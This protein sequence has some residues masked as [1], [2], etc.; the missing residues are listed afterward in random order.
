MTDI[1]LRERSQMIRQPLRYEYRDPAP[2][3]PQGTLVAEPLPEAEKPQPFSLV[4]LLMPLLMLTMVG[5]MVGFMVMSG[6]QLNPMMLMFPIMMI[7]G[8]FSMFSGG[9]TEDY[10]ETRRTYLRHLKALQQQAQKAQVAQ[11]QH[12]LHQHPH[13]EHLWSQLGS[14]RM[15]ER[16]HQ[17]PDAYCVRIGLGTQALCTPFDLG[18]PA[19]PEDVDPVC[20]YGLKQLVTNF[21]TIADM[22]IVIHLRSF[23]ALDFSGP[24][25]HG[26]VFSLL[27]E[28][29][30]FHGPETIGIHCLSKRFSASI[31]W[32]PHSHPT[33]C[34]HAQ[35]VIV[36]V[37][38]E[39]TDTAITHACALYTTTV[40]IGVEARAGIIHQH[41]AT[42]G[43]AF[44]VNNQH[45][46][47]AVTEIGA[48]HIGTSD[49]ISEQ[50]FALFTRKMTKYSR[51]RHIQHNHT[52]EL[53]QLLGVDDF[54]A[55][56][57]EY[58]WHPRGRQ[59]LAV[60]LGIGEDH[61]PVVLDIKEASQGGMGPHGLC[62]GATGSGKSELLRT[63]VVGL[64]AT[65]SPAELNFILVD[66]KGGATFLG[67]EELPHTSAVIT[68]LA[69]E[70]FL[71]DRMHDAIAGEMNRRQELLRQAGNFSNI[72]EYNQAAQSVRHS[73]DQQLR[74]I[75]SD[76]A[77]T[78]RQPLM[79][80]P[81]LFIIIDEFSELLG[82]HPDFADVF[83]AVGRLGR[84]LGIHLLL[85]SQRLEEGKLRGL[86]SHLSYRIGLKTF[87]AAES[88]QVLGVTDAYH[89]PSK[90]GAGYLQ[91]NDGQL[92]R[93]QAAYVSGKHMIAQ[94]QQSSQ[95][96]AI[97]VWDGFVADQ[98]QEEIIMV[99]DERGTVID[100]LVAATTQV[101]A[102]RD[103]RA[104]E[105]WLAPL[106]SQI[107]FRSLHRQPAFLQLTV[108]MI[109]RP[110]YQRQDPYVLDLAGQHGHVVICGG[111]QTGKTTALLTCALA[112]IYTHDST[113]IRI[114]V[115]DLVGTNFAGLEE[116]PHV[117][118]V[119]QRGE[120]ERTERIVDEVTGFLDQPVTGHVLLLI[121]GWHELQLNYEH[122]VAKIT[123]IATDGL[124]VGVHVII[125]TPRW[126]AMRPSLRDLVTQRI[127][128]KLGES[129]DSV[130]DRAAQQQ[131]PDRPG[132]GL[133][134][135]GEH[136]LFAQVDETDYYE[137]FAAVQAYDPVPALRMLPEYCA[138][139]SL[140]QH[141]HGIAIGIGGPQLTEITWDYSKISHV[142][143]IGRKQSGKTNIIRMMLHALTLQP[144]EHVRLIVI[145]QQRQHLDYAEHPH[146]VAYSA[147][148]KKTATVLQDLLVTL[149]R[150][151][152]PA[153]IT[154]KEL[155]DH[156]WWQGPE[157][158][159]VIDDIDVLADEHLREL[160]E[161]IS[162]AKDIGFHIIATRKTGGLSRALYHPF[163]TELK[164]QA[165]L[166]A[167]LDAEK[168]DGAIWG[169]TP[170]A[171]PPGR[172]T[173]AVQGQSWGTVQFAQV[174]EQ[175]G[176]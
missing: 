32:L 115:L 106:P 65:H 160:A 68:N 64:A 45:Q 159:L 69:E 163:F 153:E 59:H 167:V 169:V 84:S 118:G 85:A 175:K 20:A 40:I 111:P 171:F 18:Q 105:V 161:Y 24:Q 102:T 31:K 176:L 43:L 86:D 152:P 48:E 1:Q 3:L 128:F 168:E 130:I 11:Y 66:F 19:A 137:I 119:V 146:V 151:L 129:L 74:Q 87:S 155:K 109:D 30:Y 72:F 126:S 131:L 95:Q 144:R 101:A 52:D 26:A 8:A 10:D 114:Y 96:A 22:P 57:V 51:P 15:W 81:A 89:L 17:D 76:D 25:A 42:Q 38:D 91:G 71:V 141:D 122:L 127:E 136:I 103:Q 23:K 140:S 135:D 29:C 173:L 108:G 6:T 54:T 78:T 37:D 107:A 156:S 47:H 9:Q 113:D 125:S 80:L 34:E 120:R 82:Q 53:P 33:A 62:I 5:G 94:I 104:H 39:V 49:W 174:D 60:P 28:L 158:F 61:H 164:D 170:Q 79:P 13:P 112:A 56:T 148:A 41:I 16:N 70:A 150:R 145:D 157:L 166:V 165:P 46:L 44:R 124:A 142:V 75:P 116:F 77:G 149:K 21:S 83:V 99:E 97:R 98:A 92:H 172:A 154:A 4:K 138:Y 100:V 93:F 88:R 27:T 58:L 117:A 35:V 55:A 121:D 139:S 63:L 14:N 2:P 133:N 110:Y 67:L 123:R 12:E 162:Q 7:A 147:T 36:L 134:K 90:P 50:E 132:R 73:G 143:A